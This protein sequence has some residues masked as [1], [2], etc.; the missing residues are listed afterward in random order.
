MRL[1][2]ADRPLVD[3]FVEVEQ[4]RLNSH[5]ANRAAIFMRFIA[6]DERYHSML[7]LARIEDYVSANERCGRS[8]LF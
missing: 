3:N 8:T 2:T 1:R 5:I 6:G 7:L 4:I